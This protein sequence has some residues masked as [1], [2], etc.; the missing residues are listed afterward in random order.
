MGDLL[1]AWT[2]RLGLLCFVVSL[3]LWGR[4]RGGVPFGSRNLAAAKWLWG[5]GWLMFVGHML[6]AFHF[7]HHWS[8]RH[9]VAET[10][11][12]TEDLMGIAFGGGLYFNYLFLALWF[13]DFMVI[14]FRGTAVGHRQ[15]WQWLIIA[16]LAFI[17]FNGTVVFKSGGM[18]WSGVV[19]T[20]VLCY[21]LLPL[22]ATRFKKD[23]FQG[24]QN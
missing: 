7:H 18:R 6:A 1:I 3:A 12:Q 17:A 5:I 14:A 16:Y 8:H 11:Q 22:L 10:A 20:L 21:A 19:G 4:P 15:W 2:V 9:A 13:V 24:L 23:R